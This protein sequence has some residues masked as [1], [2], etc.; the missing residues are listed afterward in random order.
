LNQDAHG[1]KLH[2]AEYPFGLNI[3][4]MNDLAEKIST[5]KANLREE[6]LAQHS[7]PWVLGF[8][9]GKDSTLLAHFVVEMLKQIAPDD[10]HRPITFLSNNTL[11][12]SPIFQS[13]VD[14][15]LEVLRA[16]LTALKLPIS[17]VQTNP[18]P[19]GS[20]W[21]NLIGK[22]YPAPSPS[23]RWC[24]NHMKVKP[25]VRFLQLQADQFGGA[26]LLLGI[27]R[28]ESSQRAKTI[29]RHELNQSGEN[30]RLTPHT[31][32]ADCHIFAPIKE[33][34]TEEV[35]ALLLQLRPPWGGSYRELV[36]MYR[37]AHTGECP[38]VVSENDNASCGT[39][40]ARFG[41]W[42][43]TVVKKDRAL[44]A[45]AASQDDESLEKLAAFRV[46]IK[47]ISDDPANR[48]LV[49]RN[50]Q[51]GLGPLNLEARRLLLEELLELQHDVHRPLISDEEVCLIHSQWRTDETTDIVRSLSRVPPAFAPA[52][53]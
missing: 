32:V 34:T 16:N 10:R 39:S 40:N 19:K 46:R 2:Q 18:E 42:T 43:C 38:F 49:R 20:F 8:S 21:F 35:W 44:D 23:F 3:K 1:S 11:V 17:I 50:G 48:S 26:I 27:R 41:C 53:P 52:I 36:G 45:L 24:T 33:F 12:E 13:Y 30:N 14:R 6:Y 51:P 47:Q 31:D 9:G 25:T 15:Q 29:A 4:R 7:W 28:S 5:L 37:D 22:G